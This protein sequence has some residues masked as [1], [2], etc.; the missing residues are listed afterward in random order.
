RREDSRLKVLQDKAQELYS[1]SENALVLVEK[2][3][4]LVAIFMGGTFTAEQG[5]MQNIDLLISLNREYVTLKDRAEL[6][7]A[8]HFHSSTLKDPK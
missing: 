7:R 1:A 4:K 6:D 8:G 3:G 2:L 5:D